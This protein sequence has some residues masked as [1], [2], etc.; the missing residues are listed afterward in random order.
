MVPELN[1][2]SDYEVG[3]AELAFT[4]DIDPPAPPSGENPE[5]TV[6]DFLFERGT[7]PKTYGKWHSAKLQN[8][9]V[10]KTPEQLVQALNKILLHFIPRLKQSPV[11]PFRYDVEI[12][13]I[14]Y[15]YDP[16]SFYLVLIRGF[17]IK[18]MG[19]AKIETQVS[20]ICLG[21][22][23]RSKYYKFEKQLREFYAGC[24]ERFKTSCDTENYADFSP[25]NSAL[26]HREM[27]LYTN[28]VAPNPVG[29]ALISCL[30]FIDLQRQD[31]GC[32]VVKTFPKIF[33]YP[34]SLHT[35]SEI[36]IEFRELDGQ[37]LNLLGF[38]R[39]SLHFRPRKTQPI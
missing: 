34:V 12:D 6:F 39:V 31:T 27:L 25:L 24:R 3:L 29:S 21:H 2:N 17:L 28:I 11:P 35:I 5:V 37:F 30:R 14:Y 19:L 18:L 32:H 33:Y 38:S 8:L 15:F 26:A 13:R 16:G 36:K 4:Q 20:Y 23:K 9:A 22:S 1:M 10:L 7:E